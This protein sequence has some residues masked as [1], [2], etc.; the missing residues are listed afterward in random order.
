MTKETGNQGDKEAPDLGNNRIAE[1]GENAEERGASDE[2]DALR[3]LPGAIRGIYSRNGSMW[4]RP[5]MG[6]RRRITG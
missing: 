1:D 5:K 4:K 2:R 6:V 3:V